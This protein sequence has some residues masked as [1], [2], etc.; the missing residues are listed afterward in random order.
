MVEA[1]G[2]VSF[3]SD[4]RIVSHLP[5]PCNWQTRFLESEPI[6][7]FFLSNTCGTSGFRISHNST[8][9]HLAPCM[10]VIYCVR[11]LGPS[12]TT[13]CFVSYFFIFLFFIFGQSSQIK[14]GASIDTAFCTPYDSGPYS[15]MMAVL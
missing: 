4:F 3:F 14:R 7:T 15:L 2:H 9:L 6:I 12:H 11:G 13:N 10:R 5:F 8:M 1:V